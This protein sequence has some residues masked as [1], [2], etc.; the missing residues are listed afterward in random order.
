MSKHSGEKEKREKPVVQTNSKVTFY[1]ATS[2]RVVFGLST[3][4]FKMV[5]N[6][7][8]SKPSWKQSNNILPL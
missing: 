3:L 8:F 7:V 1:I 5:V 2:L 4:Y 6:Q